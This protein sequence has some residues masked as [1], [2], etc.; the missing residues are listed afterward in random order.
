MSFSENLK[1]ALSQS[2]MTMTDL[3]NSTGITYNMIK[4]YCAGG[5][6]PTV[7][8]ALKIAETLNV[9]I[10]ELMDY[11]APEQKNMF[12]QVFER[13]FTYIEGFLRVVRRLPNK[14]AMVDPHTD[15]TWTYSQLNADVNKLSNALLDHNVQKGDVVL[16]QLPNCPE[17]VFSYLAPQKFGAVTSP[18]NP[19]FAPEESKV[20]L[21]S[22]EPKVY[23]YDEANKDN[24]V[25][26]LASADA[27]PELILMVGD[28]ELPEGHIRFSDFVRDY[29][30]TEPVTDFVPYIYDEMMRLYTSGT[31]GKPKEY[32]YTTP[33][34]CLLAM[35]L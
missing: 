28:G 24:S 15:S 25:K 34:K 11:R 9:S 27:K 30:D 8:Y 35:M 22:S 19:G 5:A 16:F 33:M 13:D 1:N 26:A 14:E 18:A 29:P 2:N 10:D 6:D 4:K 31:T 3:A 17:F 20:C 32:H 12:R 21:D 23:I 7:S